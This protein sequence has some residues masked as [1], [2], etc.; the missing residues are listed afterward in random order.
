ML[1]NILTKIR[2]GEHF[3]SKKDF[4]AFLEVTE[5]QINRYEKSA[6]QPPL[7]T[8]IKISNKLNKTVNEIWSI[9]KE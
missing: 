4:A 2:M 9:I 3:M 6:Q 5:M 8:A 7:E 1:K